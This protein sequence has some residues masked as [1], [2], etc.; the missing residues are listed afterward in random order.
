LL[1]NDI[2]IFLIT[3][4]YFYLEFSSSFI[5]LTKNLQGVSNLANPRGDFGQIEVQ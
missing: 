3:L 5:Y 1:I 4:S 2:N